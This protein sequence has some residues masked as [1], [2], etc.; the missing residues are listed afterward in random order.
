MN[1]LAHIFINYS[2][3]SFIIPDARAYLVPIA[4][5]AIILDIDHIPGCFRLSFLS[6]EAKKKL[7][8]YDYVSMFRTPIQEPIGIFILSC[9]LLLV[10]FFGVQ[11]ILLWIAALSFVLHWLADF[12]TVH[13]RP[14]SPFSTRIVSLFFHGKK[15]RIISESVITF[16]SGVVFVIYYFFI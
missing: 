10:Y 9:A 12:L 4:L 8:V 14:L 2:V 13:T 11:S 6:K 7:S 5:F 1:P 3:L 15:Q 16:L